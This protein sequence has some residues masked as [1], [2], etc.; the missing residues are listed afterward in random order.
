MRT[1]CTTLVLGFFLS[2]VTTADVTAHC[3]IPCGIYDDE[4][5]TNLI[6]EHTVTIEKSMKTIVEQSKQNPVNYNQLVRWVS[7][8]EEHATLIQQTVSQYFMT[9]RIRPDAEKYIDKLSVLHKMLQ[10][11]MKC[12]QSTDLA[13][14]QNLRSL[15]KQFEILYFGHSNH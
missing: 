9:Q 3:E 12:K 10:A 2:F 8:K 4:L 1:I 5:R 13:D 14:V 11:A 6:Y 15:I 7:N